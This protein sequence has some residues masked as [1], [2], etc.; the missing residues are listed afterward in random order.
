MSTRPSPDPSVRAAWWNVGLA[1]LAFASLGIIVYVELAGL[2]RHDPRF[3]TL[4]TLDL[5]V[6]LVLLADLVASFVRADSK[7]RWL[8]THWYEI[9]GLVPLYAETLSFL[10]LAQLA[11]LARVLRLL[12]AMTAFRHVRPSV[13]FL[14]ALLNRGKLGH[15]LLVGATIVL[16]LGLVVWMLERDTNPRM[17]TFGE[18]L[19]WAI[20]TVTTVGY[21]DITPQT[22]LARVLA[23]VLMMLGIGTVGVVASSLSTALLETDGRERAAEPPLVD[24]L[25]RLASLRERGALSEDEFAAAKR[26]LLA[27]RLSRAQASDAA[28]AASR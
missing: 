8:R 22:G 3:R 6:V 10:R 14:D 1:A 20:V 17:Q 2:G 28:Q 24:A 12:R 18:A 27:E 4:A 5:V 16:A 9:L 11:R 25:E 13:R 21:G 7:T 19:W 15:A 23:T 26:R